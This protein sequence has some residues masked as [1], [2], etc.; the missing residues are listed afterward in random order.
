M[1][2][3]EVDRGSTIDRLTLTGVLVGTL[4]FSTSYGILLVLPLYITMKLGGTEANYGLVTSSA[5]VTAIA[6]LG[7]LIRFPTRIPSNY[8]LAASATAYALGAFGVARLDSFGVPMVAFGLLLG[9]S[10][11][12]G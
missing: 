10:W 11:A 7:L 8:L 12:I 1:L 6:C 4:A 2:P 5:T 9:T 3:N